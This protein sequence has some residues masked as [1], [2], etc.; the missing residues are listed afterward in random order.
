LL[1]NWFTDL[2]RYIRTYFWLGY[3]LLRFRDIFDTFILLVIFCLAPTW[4]FYSS[5]ITSFS[6]STA[7]L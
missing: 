3:S 4:L 7:L 5:F 2:V 1:L 6:T